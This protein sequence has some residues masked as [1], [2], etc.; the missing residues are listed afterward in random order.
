MYHLSYIIIESAALV[1]GC[2]VAFVCAAYII[3]TATPHE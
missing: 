2:T 3:G 1:I